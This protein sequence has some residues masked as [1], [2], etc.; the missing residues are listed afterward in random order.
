MNGT[1]VW[2]SSGDTRKREAKAEVD[3]HVEAERGTNAAGA[4]AMTVGR[5]NIRRDIMVATKIRGEREYEELEL[6]AEKL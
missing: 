1:G 4:K 3:D 6:V 5:T 2:A